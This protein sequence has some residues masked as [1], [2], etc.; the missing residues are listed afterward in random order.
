MKKLISVFILIVFANIGFAQTTF[1]DGTSAPTAEEVSL[2]RDVIMKR[3]VDVS[4]IT[5]V[6]IQV[7]IV[8]K[9]NSSGGLSMADLNKGLGTLNH[10]FYES[11]IQFFLIGEMPNYI[12]DDVLFEYQTAHEA[13]LVAKGESTIALNVYFVDMINYIGG[14]EYIWGVSRFPEDEAS[15]NRI[16]I[17]SSTVADGYSL[18]QEF[19]HY[20]GLL[21]TFGQNDGVKTDETADGSNCSTAGDLICDTPADPFSYS[22]KYPSTDFNGCTYIGNAVDN[23]ANKYNPPVDNF[24]SVYPNSCKERFTTNQY[25]RMA[26]G[27]Q[28]R[29]SHSNY[30]LSAVSLSVP[31][32]SGL[33]AVLVDNTVQLT[34]TDNATNETGYIIERSVQDKT[35]GFVAIAG[36]GVEKD[37]TSFTDNTIEANKTY[38]YR[39]RPSNS[40]SSYSNVTDGVD[41]PLVYCTP[42]YTYSNCETGSNLKIERVKIQ[43][44]GGNIIV[45]QPSDCSSNIAEINNFTYYSSSS[46]PAVNISLAARSSYDFTIST[47]DINQHVTIWL[48]MNRDGRFSTEEILF[49]TEGRQENSDPKVLSGY[50]LPENIKNGKSRLRIRTRNGN[51]DSNVSDPCE[52]YSIGETEDYEVNLVG[53]ITDDTPPVFMSSTPTVTNEAISG[54]DVNVVMSEPGKAYFI[55]VA[56]GT[57]PTVTSEQVKQGMNSDWQPA[58]ASGTIEVSETVLQFT[59]TLTGLAT[60]T[61]Y[62]VYVV[63]EDKAFIPNL[64]TLPYKVDANTIVPTADFSADKALLY[65]GQSVQFTDLS[66]GAGGRWSWDFGDGKSASTQ[67]PLHTFEVAGEFSITLRINDGLGITTKEKYIQVLPNRSV[68]YLVSDGGNFE[69]NTADFGAELLKGSAQLWQRGNPS[70][71]LETLNSPVTG[72]KTMLNSNVPQDKNESALLTPNFDFSRAGSYTLSFFKSM[73]N[74]FFDGPY[75]VQ[76]HYSLDKGESWVRLGSYNDEKGQNWYNSDPSAG[77]SN[78]VVADMEGWLLSANNEH[79]TYD[80]SFLA[81]NSDVAFRFVIYVDNSYGVSSYLDGF[82]VDDFELQY[83]EPTADFRSDRQTVFANENITFEDASIAVTSWLWDFGD[84]NTSVQQNPTHMYEAPGAYNVSL[85]INGNDSYI[86]RRVAYINVLEKPGI[87]YQANFN[88]HSFGWKSYVITGSG[89]NKWEWGQAVKEDLGTTLNGEASWVTTL[90]GGHGMNTRYALESPPFVMKKGKGE[91]FLKFAYKGISGSDP[92][93][94]RER[95]GMKLEYRTNGGAWKVLGETL[96]GSGDAKAIKDWYNHDNIDGLGGE[97]GWF[98]KSTSTEY[99]EYDISEF[100]EAESV[101]F[102]FV[103]GAGTVE[104]DGFQIDDFIITGAQIFVPGLW[105][106]EQSSV[107]SNPDNWDNLRVPT[108]ETDIVI[109]EVAQPPI[110]DVDAECRSITIEPGGE[111]KLNKGVSLTVTDSVYLKA[112]KEKYACWIDY[113][114]NITTDDEKTVVEQVILRDEDELISLMTVDKEANYLKDGFPRR[115]NEAE[116]TLWEYMNFLPGQYERIRGYQVKFPSGNS[117]SLDSAVIQHEKTFNSNTFSYTLKK[118]DGKLGFSLVGN[119]YPAY[120]DWDSE[121]WIRNELEGNIWVSNNSASEYNGTMGV[122]NGLIGVNGATNII[123]PGQGFFVKS[124]D[125]GEF[126]VTNEIKR[127]R[128]NLVRNTP[129][130]EMKFLYVNVKVINGD[131]KDQIALGF[132]E[133]AL[134]GNDSFDATKMMSFNQYVPNIYWIHG[135]LA[136]TVTDDRRLAINYQPLESLNDQ[137]GVLEFP[138]GFSMGTPSPL[139]LTVTELERF[140]EKEYFIYLRDKVANTYD[141]MRKIPQ[142]NFTIEGE[143]QKRY[144]LVIAKY[145]LTT[146]VENLKQGW[147]IYGEEGNIKVVRKDKVYNDYQLGLYDLSGRLLKNLKTSRPEVT[148]QVPKEGVYLLKVNEKKGSFAQKI[149]IK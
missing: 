149:Y 139:S 41:I 4:S 104:D 36:G 6:P 19:G 72:W 93:T 64:M 124:I 39:L 37:V 138:I 30:G 109:P 49:Q 91:Y 137:Q 126:G 34:W 52:E 59:R 142:Y 29:L 38:Y 31:A 131:Y 122:Y 123:K 14:S 63:G 130:E 134:A 128:Y 81:G 78:T 33:T 7:H 102:R 118:V 48:D 94:G 11:G 115:Y 143:E 42:K 45:D 117:V 146:G 136:E 46:S 141:D 147:R 114:A 125:A 89:D 119:P 53:G 44:T 107:W 95:A 26:Q 54:F 108:K 85:T 62:D 17:K 71:K 88:E 69:A 16:F 18:L 50:V 113:G 65:Q 32:P 82:M 22:N 1:R 66:T 70:G 12:N 83:I 8:R 40:S 15:H 57:S 77:I 2:I 76:V 87:P 101:Q 103:F 68:P 10:Y 58:L 116:E 61:S 96:Q 9:S 21:N 27:L 105:T 84:G 86:K 74:M 120:V 80:V 73:E 24:M 92:I 127:S 75:A 140:D 3:T 129:D 79:T 23:F 35:S 97:M 90:N 148:I 121:G 20:F 28:E 111:M 67:N 56:D 47:N 133:D 55:V 43:E 25:T 132:D 110:L 144:S 5:F 145:N 135:D 99:P 60:G 13:N 100:V 106:G 112:T 98:S 51:V